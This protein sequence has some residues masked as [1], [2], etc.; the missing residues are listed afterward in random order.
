VSEAGITAIILAG[1]RPGRDPLAAAV[2]VAWKALVP[3]AGR[4][5]L[6]HVARTLTGHARIG[7]IIVMAQEPEAL[8]NHPQ[9]AWLNGK[10]KILFHASGAGISQSLLDWLDSQPQSQP[11]L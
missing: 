1:S 4:P 5:M 6:D 3:V 7:K 2:G 9:T 8:G 11:V 10:P